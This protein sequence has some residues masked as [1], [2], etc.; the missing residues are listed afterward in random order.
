MTTLAARRFPTMSS[1]A[2]RQPMAVERPRTW[3]VLFGLA[4]AHLALGPVLHQNAELA[5]AHAYATLAVGLYWALSSSDSM[6][7]AYVAAYATGAEVLWRMSGAQIF[8]EFGKYAVVVMF[9]ISIARQRR[10]D[11]SARRLAFW[12]FVLM[13]P[14]AM[15][16]VFD[17]GFAAREALSFN[18]S[19]PLALVVS[20]VFFTGLT[21]SPAER[22]TMCLA[23]VAPLLAI[24]AITL[25]GILAD[26]ELAFG[27]ESNLQASGNFG[28]N[29]VSTALTMGALVVLFELLYDK[30]RFRLLFLPVLVF[31]T[32]QSTLT[33]SR[34]GL[35]SFF[36]AAGAGLVFLAR[37]R[38]VRGALVFVA[39][40]A[41]AAYYVVLPRLDS[42]TGGTLVSRFS[43]TDLTGRDEL[44]RADLEVWKENPVFGVG[45]G[46]AEVERQ[47]FIKYAP[48]HTEFSRMIAEHGLFGVASLIVIAV[49]FIS[50]VRRT[51][52]G[53]ERMIVVSLIA[54]GALFTLHAG[55]RL[56][57]PSFAI[58][59]SCAS[60]AM[61]RVRGVARGRGTALVS[62]S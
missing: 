25:T 60:F 23:L 34:G 11:S 28:P 38:R 61:P 10:P 41:A 37:D 35:F 50:N 24:A 56:V 27:T 16:P 55:M 33:F 22:R 57:A 4:L 3:V 30:S 13:L 53:P 19:G 6:R 45:P 49:M 58:G 48:S 21:V 18:L 5:T 32:V 17:L 2:A 39:I 12:Y 40:L 44:V 1:T 15:I 26:P 36:G 62:R 7:V 47:R 14:S 42:L 9:L 46:Q 20:T 59:L 43:D 51:R 8:W 52:S 54:W 31:L 29:Q